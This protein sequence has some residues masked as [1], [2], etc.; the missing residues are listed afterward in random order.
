MAIQSLESCPKHQSFLQW[1]WK[2]SSAT[3]VVSDIT[4]SIRFT[5]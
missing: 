4:T 5:S 3:L 1:S 2:A